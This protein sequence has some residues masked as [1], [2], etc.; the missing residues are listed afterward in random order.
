MLCCHG[1]GPGLA[2]VGADVNGVVA[3]ALEGEVEPHHVDRDTVR[4][5]LAV[6]PG[7][8]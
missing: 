5:A 7:L 2:A 8:G 4:A 6:W 3:V 1:R